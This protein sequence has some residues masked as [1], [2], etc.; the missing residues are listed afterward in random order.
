MPKTSSSEVASPETNSRGGDGDGGGEGGGGGDGGGGGEGSEGSGGSGG[1]EAGATR[2]VGSLR[3]PLGALSKA[4]DSSGA[5]EAILMNQHDWSCL[6]PSGPVA[7]YQV[8]R[9]RGMI[10]RQCRQDCRRSMID[11]R[12]PSCRFGSPT[13]RQPLS[14]CW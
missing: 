10:P 2:E 14:F 12:L 8:W 5:K 3:L 4:R 1:A 13:S 11:L 7:A 9:A 6:P